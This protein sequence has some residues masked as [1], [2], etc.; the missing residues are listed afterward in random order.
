MPSIRN[1][2]RFRELTL[3][4]TKTRLREEDNLH[5]AHHATCRASSAAC[6]RGFWFLRP[7]T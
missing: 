3:Y 4:T 6:R 5:Y 7:Q 2:I 1:I